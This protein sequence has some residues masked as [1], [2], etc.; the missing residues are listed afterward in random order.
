[1]LGATTLVSAVLGKNQTCAGNLA[2][3]VLFAPSSFLFDSLDVFCGLHLGA[4]VST[5]CAGLRVCD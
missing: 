1:M 2:F 5:N 4:S 3:S